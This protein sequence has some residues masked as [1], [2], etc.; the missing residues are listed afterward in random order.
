MVSLVLVGHSPEL[1]RGLRAM[2]AQASSEVPVATAGGTSI[3]HLGT[4]SPAIL[5]ALKVALAAAAGDGVVVL[6]DLG[7]AFL[8]LEMAL[9]E[10]SSAERAAV[11]VSS[12]PLVEGAV[13]AAI[14]ASSGAPLDRVAA[15]ADAAY[16]SPKLP[17]GW[18]ETGLPGGGEIVGRWMRRSAAGV[19]AERVRLTDLDAAI[20]DGD[21]GINL[22]RGFAAVVAGLDDGSLPDAAPGPLLAAVGRTLSRTV[23]G[24]SGAL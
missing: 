2:I 1:L 10:L 14:E 13:L 3:G 9:E 5:A 18:T 11:R 21:H 8:A 17:E 19:A 6:I 24:A 23:G 4:S 22:D 15:V 7:S 12:G 16:A 20:G